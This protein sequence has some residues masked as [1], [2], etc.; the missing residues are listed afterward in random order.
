MAISMVTEMAATRVTEIIS[1]ISVKPR[2]EVFLEERAS[3]ASF[4]R[5]S[6]GV[7]ERGAHI[8]EISRFSKP[9]RNPSSVK[10]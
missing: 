5:G 3:T 4:G 10:L 6:W 9:R 8:L 1:S 7:N 2:C